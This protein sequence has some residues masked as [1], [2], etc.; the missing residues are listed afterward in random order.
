MGYRA[1]LHPL[2]P[3]EVVQSG[4]GIGFPHYTF[5][6]VT[7]LQQSRVRGFNLHF[8]DFAIITNGLRSRVPTCWEIFLDS[9]AWNS[10]NF[11]QTI[12]Y[13]Y[14]IHFIRRTFL[15]SLTKLIFFSFSTNYFILTLLVE[16]YYLS[17]YDELYYFLTLIIKRIFP[18][19][20]N[21]YI[22]TSLVLRYSIYSQHDLRARVHVV[23]GQRSQVSHC[24]Y[25]DCIERSPVLHHVS[26]L[27]SE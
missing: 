8:L 20:T 22:I 3:C 7:F 23:I 27:T 26:I 2:K 17:P 14:R 12:K 13:F 19:L 4:M 16:T 10:Y 21:S 15:P 9:K 11:H 1:L 18:T 6:T 25:C 24:S 5:V